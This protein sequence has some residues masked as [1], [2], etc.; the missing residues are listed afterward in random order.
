MIKGLILHDTEM[1]IESNFVDSHGQSEVAFPFCRF[2]MINLLPRLKR[3]KYERLYLPEKVTE[4][5]FS[6]LKGVLT[7]PIRWDHIYNQYDEMVRHVVAAV[8]K[9]GPIESILRRFNTNN[10]SHPT[11]KA[12]VEAGKAL[13]TTHICSYLTQPSLRQEI[14]DG[15]NIIENWNSANSF[16]CYG[17]K[18]EIQTN[19]PEMQELTILC[20]HLL[21]NALILVNTLTVERVLYEDGFINRM[22]PEDFHALTPLFTLNM[23]PYGYFPLD[24]NKPSI[25]EAA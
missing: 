16:I 4:G 5:Q 19:D 13:K 17:H 10:R 3:I 2:L 21:Q 11:Y 15:L 14:H 8:E 6:H 24:L 9:T 12:F 20:L 1:R 25:L 22:E 18:S 7:R 23:N